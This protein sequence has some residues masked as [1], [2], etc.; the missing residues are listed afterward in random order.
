MRTKRAA[1]LVIP[2]L[3]G[4]LLPKGVSARTITALGSVSITHPDGSP[5]TELVGVVVI[6]GPVFLQTITQQLPESA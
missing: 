3:L 5:A 2:L 6:H 4:L 1:L